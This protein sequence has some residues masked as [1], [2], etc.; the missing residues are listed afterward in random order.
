MKEGKVFIFSWNVQYSCSN[1]IIIGIV[2]IE[3][4]RHWPMDLQ[5]TTVMDY[6]LQCSRQV[7]IAMAEV[8]LNAIYC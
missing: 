6:M 7:T 8:N 3:P 5:S 2:M 4:D 1:A